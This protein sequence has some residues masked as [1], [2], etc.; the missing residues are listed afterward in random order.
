MAY[1]RNLVEAEASIP[2]LLAASA[3]ARQPPALSPPG[4]RGRGRCWGSVAY[5]F[6]L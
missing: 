4:R 6:Y 3:L 5:G 2:A 1:M